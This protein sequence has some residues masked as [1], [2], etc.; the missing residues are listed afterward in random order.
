LCPITLILLFETDGLF[1]SFGVKELVR[2]S[3]MSFVDLSLDLE[4]VNKVVSFKTAL[5]YRLNS[6]P[7]E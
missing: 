6:K 4:V 5:F 3:L 2:Y 1:L 7:E